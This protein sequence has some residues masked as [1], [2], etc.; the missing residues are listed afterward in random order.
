M[1]QVSLEMDHLF[2]WDRRFEESL[3]KRPDRTLKKM[4]EAAREVAHPRK[5][6]TS[7]EEVG[8]GYLARPDIL[9]GSGSTPSFDITTPAKLI[10]SVL[11]WNFVGFNLT[12]YSSHLWNRAFAIFF[13]FH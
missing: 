10:F 2:S 12:L 1:F 11:N 5:A 8:V 6:L 9:S 4:E 13:T 3:L 7:F